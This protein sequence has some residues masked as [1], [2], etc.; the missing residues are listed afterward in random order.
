MRSRRQLAEALGAWLKTITRDQRWCIL[1]NADPDAMGAAAALARLMHGRA[2]DVD[3][4]RINEITRPDNLAMMRYLR[5]DVQPWAPGLQDAYTH[6]AI[7]DSQPHH[8]AAFRGIPF[9]AIIDHH[10]LPRPEQAPT[11]P[12]AFR[13]IRPGI[14]A[15]CTLLTGYL[16]ALGIRPTPRLATALL[17]GIRTDT[18]AFERG[19]SEDDLAAY[20]WL[21]RKADPVLQRR[22]LRSEY[23]RAWLP[24]FSRAFQDLRDCR[25]AGAHAF[26]GVVTSPDLLVAIA[27]F[28][29]R[30]HGLKWIAV[31]G[32]A[33]RTVVVI[34]R[35]DG[36]R[37]IGRMA[38]ACF[39][40]VGS[41]G[42]HR[43]LGRAEFPLA[44]VPAGTDPG[45]FVQQR[46]QT[47]KLR[48]LARRADETDENAD[49]AGD[50]GTDNGTGD[51]P[52]EGGA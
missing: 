20:Q 7:V 36:S 44:A 43:T 12:P 41:G 18:A 4:R 11:P 26:L 28:F 22:I 29:T 50:D 24:L 37:D 15:T 8:N 52:E 51:D 25:G 16:Q 14:G 34:F 6:F 40:D 38:D 31:S 9:S 48:P 2:R 13:D 1:I 19:G 30:V 27:D 23:L 21:S 47:R 17:L 42:G 39:H 49:D 46:L 35:G 3:I 32:I 45:D 10:A 5:L 33:K